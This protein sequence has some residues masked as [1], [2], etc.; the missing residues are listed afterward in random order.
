MRTQTSA[1]PEPDPLPTRKSLLSRLRDLEDHE[2]WKEFF[3]TYWPLIYSVARKMRLS[4]AEAQDVVQ[5]TMVHMTKKL[6]EF[7]YDPKRGSFRGWLRRAAYW[8][9]VDQIRL[10]LPVDELQDDHP[11][12]LENSDPPPAE[13]FDEI[14]DEEEA[15][16]I[17]RMATRLARERVSDQQYQ[18][19]QLY[20]TKGWPAKKV[21]ETLQ[22][23]VGRVY[24]AKFRFTDQLKK[25]LKSIKKDRWPV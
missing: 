20:V 7:R 1:A 12:K 13:A 22:I 23:S 21:A 15:Q 17:I 2:G 14:W 4:D 10:R 9:I 16:N 18:I 19:Y 3:E 24:L 6:P 8:R 25:E 11:P 5:E